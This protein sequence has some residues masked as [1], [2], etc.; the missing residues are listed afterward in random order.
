MNVERRIRMGILLQ[1]MN[2]QKKY[3]K[4]LKLEDVSRFRGKRVNQI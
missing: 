2:K 1:K 3:S 4:K